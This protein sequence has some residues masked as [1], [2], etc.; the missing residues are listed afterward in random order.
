[1]LDG[2]TSWPE[3]FARR[4]IQEGIWE[5]KV[6]W[7][8]LREAAARYPDR[9]F[10]ADG[11]KKLSYGEIV[12][13]SERVA[14]HLLECGMQPRDIVLLQLPNTWEFVV[15]FYALRRVGVIPI[16]CL[17]PHRQT[18]LTYFAQLT[19]AKGYVFAP[20]Y[21]GF[22]YL[23]MAREIQAAVPSLRCLIAAGDGHDT[24]VSYLAP[25]IERPARDPQVLA[26]YR[27]DPFDVALFLLSGGTTGIPKLIP[28]TAA[29]YLYNAKQCVRVLDW[30]PDT[31]FMVVI[32]AAHNFPL[33]A[34]GMIGTAMVGGTLAMCPSPDPET[35]FQAVQ[36]HKGTALAASPALL[37]SLLNSPHLG[38]YDLS[39]LRLICVGG[40]KMQPELA[41][42][43][44]STW[45]FATPV[46]VFGMAEGLI[47]MTR[48]DDPRDVILHTQGRPI[49]PADEIRIVGDD[50]QEVARGEVGELL[51]R[52]PYTVRG[53]YKAEEH[54]RVAFTP[55]GFYRTGDM[56]RQDSNGN[57]VVEGRRKDMI[58]RGGE[59]ISAE[60]IENL[61]LSHDSVHMAAVV[62]MPDPV[63]GER[64]C[65]FVIP[66]PERTLTL[67]E[68]TRFLID[69]KIAKFKLPERLEVVPQFPLTSVGKISKKDL[70]D[71]IAAKL[72]AEG[73]L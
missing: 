44:W 2:C 54:N 52:G 36:R 3:D 18:E 14:V 63:M 70:R 45:P 24:G 35:V 50:G 72:K 49:S 20:S 68:L 10:V 71:Q 64:S 43:V 51:T 22:D 28:R 8:P 15:M 29:D 34:P 58:N 4:Y 41:D 31:V 19:G 17:P 11:E 62:A 27:T 23:A 16:M 39:S 55:D 37:I 53:Y 59:K 12:Q 67:D 61:V 73:K 56:V 30:G 13:L 1:M 9:T 33:S 26:Y 40:Q 25:C 32:P 47:N 57:L 21:R 46:Q 48:P 66:R 5:P 6:L 65:A 38:K 42:R 7:D 69:K 60:E